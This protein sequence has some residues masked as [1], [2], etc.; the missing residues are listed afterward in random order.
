M[1]YRFA[2]CDLDTN[3]HTVTLRG[4]P[5]HVE[6]QVFDVLHLLAEAAGGLVTYDRLVER[7]W[8]GRIVS[9]ATIAAR[10]S[11]A[12]AAVGDD[13][14][15]QEIIETVTRRG[16]RLVVATTSEP[17]HAEKPQA[18][19]PVPHTVRM[20]TSSDCT[21][22]AWSALGEGPPLL[23]AGHWLTH[24]E[25]DLSSA[26]WGPWIARLSQNR[27]LLRY[28]PRGTGMSAR[29]CPDTSID[30]AVDD[31]AAVADA[32]G[33]ES[34]D[35]L[36]SSQSAAIAF[37]FAARFPE[38]VSRIVTVGGFVQG[39]RVRAPDDGS[40]LSDT[41][42]L[43]IRQG[44]GQPE[45]GFLRSL[46]TLF[47]PSASQDELNEIL[48]LQAA[49]ADADRAVRI[50]NTCSYYDET[51]VLGRVTA[52]VLV[53]HGLDDS[54]HPFSQA[55]LIAALLPDARILQ[56]A[57]PNHLIS[58]REPAFEVLMQAIDRF[59]E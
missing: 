58:P 9:D 56:L 43:M 35:I 26:I 19:L 44:W 36:A 22:I 5:V 38:R 14:K 4:V 23:R 47:M 7:V 41:M 15:R 59:L 3:A 37:H 24:L 28:D 16:I 27:Q 29:A 52:P 10:I 55:Q 57:T 32:A 6:P 34:F 46:G 30:H 53:A 45:S 51:D 8:K 20:T 48:Q 25:K 33:L 42:E 49:S 54:I 17:G 13:G 11:A 2:D 31:L 1:K 21:M 12:R 39:T 40:A 50:R 18:D